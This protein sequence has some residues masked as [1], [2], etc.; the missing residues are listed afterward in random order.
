[1][2]VIIN[3]FGGTRIT[4]CSNGFRAFRIDSLKRVLLLQDQF[5]TAELILDAAKK[6]IRIGEVPV[7]V[8]RR[9]SGESKKG[10]NL[11]YGYNFA[12]TIFKTWWRE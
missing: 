10:R 12:K 4:D 8:K 9:L 1:M 5:H 7:T 2:S 6:G 11:A 3:F